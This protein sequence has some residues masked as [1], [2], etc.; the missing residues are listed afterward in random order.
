MP[1]PYS[2]FPTP[3]KGLFQQ[4][5]SSETPHPMTMFLKLHS[6]PN[7]SQDYYLQPEVFKEKW[8]RIRDKPSP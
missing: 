8:M 6:P 5:L 1:I 2:L 3:T 7:N 4:A